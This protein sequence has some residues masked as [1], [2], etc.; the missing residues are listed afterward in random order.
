M[1]LF[2][3]KGHSLDVGRCDLIPHEMRVTDDSISNTA[4]RV[5]W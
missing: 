2:S 4:F 3:P 1:T 5:P